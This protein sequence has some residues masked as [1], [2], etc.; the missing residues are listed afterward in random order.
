[1]PSHATPSAKALRR[2]CP[3]SVNSKRDA[4]TTSDSMRRAGALGLR[5]AG[6][7]RVHGSGSTTHR[8]CARRQAGGAMLFSRHRAREADSGRMIA[9]Q[10][11]SELG[12][13][14]TAH[15]SSAGAALEKPI[16]VHCS[17]VGAALETPTAGSWGAAELPS[18]LGG[19]RAP[20]CSSAGD[21]RR[22]RTTYCDSFIF[23][24]R[25]ARLGGP[26][27]Q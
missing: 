13:M 17:S 4:P 6:A 5:A 25:R 12:G 16:A 2:P 20:H 7:E 11:P 23:S 27:D 15:C 10:G 18:E 1:M 9:A 26:P 24:R 22:T 8:V 3:P 19:G 21:R 14:R